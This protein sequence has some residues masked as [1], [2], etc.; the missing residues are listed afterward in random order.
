MTSYFSEIMADSPLT[1]V[2]MGDA[3]G[4]VC[5]DSSG[6]GRNGAYQGSP[7]LGAPGLLTGDPDTAVTFA[8]ASSQDVNF[9]TATWLDALT[10]FTVSAIIVP[11]NVTTLQQIVARDGTSN[12]SFQFR[13]LNTGKISFVKIPATTTTC[14]GATTLVAGNKYHVAAVFDA[15][16]GSLKVYLN[17][18]QDATIAVSGSLATSAQALR[19]AARTDST[20]GTPVEFFN[21][22]IDEVALFGTAL[23]AARIAAQNTA[24]GT[25]P[26]PTTL[27]GTWGIVA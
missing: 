16:G 19:I 22:T 15:P 27:T 26:S 17:G 25:A 20:S 3:S 4:T 11:T 9:T 24:M 6:N 23:S 2:R 21:G 14:T 5:T 13:I 10:T 12:R 8:S 1:Y 18:V 7:T